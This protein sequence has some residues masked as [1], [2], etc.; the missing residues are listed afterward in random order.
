[1]TP[2]FEEVTPERRTWEFNDWIS[3]ENFIYKINCE[4]TENI[5]RWDGE[6]DYYWSVYLEDDTRN[7][8]L[9]KQDK[10]VDL[11][12]AK[13]ESTKYLEIF[14]KAYIEIIKNE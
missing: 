4:I 7:L 6:T 12:T 5:S 1:M 9:S 2:N 8:Y 10:C 13:S 11:D 3:G 14:K